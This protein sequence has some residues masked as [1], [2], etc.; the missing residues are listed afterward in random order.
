MAELPVLAYDGDL[1]IRPVGP[2]DFDADTLLR[3]YRTMLLARR[4]DEKKC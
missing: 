3:V 1:D 2:A 4:L